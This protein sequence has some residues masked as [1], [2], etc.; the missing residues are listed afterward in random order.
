[1]QRLVIGNWKMNP[2]TIGEAKKIFASFK[3]AV[4]K[5]RGVDIV[6]CPPAIFLSEIRKLYVGKKITFGAQNVFMGATGS[7]TGEMSAPMLLSAGARTVI[8]GHSERRAMGEDNDLIRK[9]VAA[10]VMAGM[11]V[12][13]CVGETARDDSGEYLTAVRTQLNTAIADLTRS[14]LSQVVVAYEPVWAIGKSASDALSPSHIHEMSIFIRK[15][16]LERFDTET[17]QKVPV[18]YGGSV[19]PSNAGSII[20]DGHVDGFLV[21]HASL[22]PTDFAT[23]ISAASA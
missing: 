9:K 17:M 16:I 14:Q 11:R 19:E 1:M 4:S 7:H 8:V 20:A 22:S 10:A 21:G 2:L 5:V 3:E 23:I 15:I 13:V 6:V 18:V 12:V